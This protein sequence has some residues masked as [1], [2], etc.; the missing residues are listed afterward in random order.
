MTQNIINDIL[1]QFID[2]KTQNLQVLQLESYDSVLSFKY[3][4]PTEVISNDIIKKK[5]KDFRISKTVY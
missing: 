5:F 1:R 2:T 4:V 3:Q